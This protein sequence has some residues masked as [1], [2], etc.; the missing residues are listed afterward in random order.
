MDKIG[1]VLV[2][3]MYHVH[4]AI[5]QDKRYWTTRW[6][7]NLDLCTILFGWQE[8]LHFIDIKRKTNQEVPVYNLRN[9]KYPDTNIPSPPPSPQKPFGPQPRPHNLRSGALPVKKEPAELAQ[10][11]VPKPYNLRSAP[12]FPPKNDPPGKSPDVNQKQ[13]HCHWLLET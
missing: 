13:R 5:I 11:A 1:I 3:M 6:D 7:H 2:A 9:P 12:V 10:P 4:I 8:S